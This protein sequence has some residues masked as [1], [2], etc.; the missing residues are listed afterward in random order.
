MPVFVLK[1]DQDGNRAFFNLSPGPDVANRSTVIEL[2][3]EGN[4]GETVFLKT[5]DGFER[6]V[7]TRRRGGQDFVGM[8]K[9]VPQL[10]THDRIFL[11]YHIGSPIVAVGMVN[12]TASI[13]ANWSGCHPGDKFYI[14]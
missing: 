14:D 5:A 2:P 7:L 13:D 11:Q 4:I 6:P 12:E 10:R 8:V 3:L 9:G 1:E